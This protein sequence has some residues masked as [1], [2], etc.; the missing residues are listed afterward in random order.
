MKR[1]VAVYGTLKNGFHNHCALGNSKFL[2]EI[3]T[4]SKFTMR[5]AGGFPFVENKGNSS[6]KVEIYEVT[7]AKDSENI[8]RLEGFNGI[9]S[10]S[11]NTFYD[12]VEIETIYGTADMFVAACDVSDLPIVKDGCWKQQ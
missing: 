8:N 3:Q 6:I 11:R 7:S 12:V 5:S 4:D 10:D 9:K 2:G 1:L